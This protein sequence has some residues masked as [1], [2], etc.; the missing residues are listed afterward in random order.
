MKKKLLLGIV[1][2]ITLFMVTG[3]KDS[4][5]KNDTKLKNISFNAPTDFEEMKRDNGEVSITN[6]KKWAS[7]RYTFKDYSIR[8][9]WREGD[10]FKVFAT[11]SKLK[12]S[13]K[14]VNGVD[15]HYSDN[16]KNLVYTVIE[17]K[18]DLYIFEYYGD[19]SSNGVK[20]YNDIVNSVAYRK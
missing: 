19:K 14:K 12:F 6:K 8:V 9:I 5:D 10:N 15:A 1:A 2:I 16:D 13:D 18:D 11:G 20:V 4:Y 3:C 17:Y 7:N